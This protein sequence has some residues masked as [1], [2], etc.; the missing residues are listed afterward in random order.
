MARTDAA[1]KAEATRLYRSGV[2]PA[3]VIARL[4]LGVHPSTVVRWAGGG[5][6]GPRRRTDVSDKRIIRLRDE[7]HLTW[8]EIGRRVQMAPTGVAKRYSR[9]KSAAALRGGAQ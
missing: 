7:K 2:R 8:A 4:G 5:T 1:G 6:P 9:A 3:D